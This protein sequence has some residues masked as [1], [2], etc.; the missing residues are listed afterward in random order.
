MKSGSRP[1]QPASCKS[2]M[3]PY[4]HVVL[5]AFFKSKKMAVTCCSWILPSLIKVSKRTSWSVVLRPLR[6]PIFV[7]V[8]SLFLSR[9]QTSLLL[10]IRS[11]RPT[12]HTQLVRAIGRSLV[13]FVVSLSGLGI[14]TIY[15]WHQ[16]AGKLPDSEYHPGQ[17]PYHWILEGV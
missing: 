1:H 13:G 17:L 11:I 8:I 3:M 14:G 4:F 6:K 7:G 10:T 9:Y 2:F 12:L 15:D 16:D 5:Y